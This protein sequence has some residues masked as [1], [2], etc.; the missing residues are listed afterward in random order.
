[1]FSFGDE[2]EETYNNPSGSMK[3]F[4]GLKG[5]C[6]ANTEMQ[7][8]CAKEESFSLSVPLMVELASRSSLQK[9]DSVLKFKGKWK[10]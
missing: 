9:I 2:V 6:A 7:S 3:R 10:W 5:G 4:L 1:M 8:S